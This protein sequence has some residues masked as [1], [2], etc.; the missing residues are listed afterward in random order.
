MGASV[1]ASDGGN[2]GNMVGAADGTTGMTVIKRTS[3]A[4][5]LLAVGL[6]TS[7][8]NTDTVTFV[9]VITGHAK[10]A[11]VDITSV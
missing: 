4:M 11:W 8:R 6:S 1:G 10:T 3:R 9:P 2:D 5:L 7:F